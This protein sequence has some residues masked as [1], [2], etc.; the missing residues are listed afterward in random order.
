LRRS[1]VLNFTPK[2][3]ESM[4][5]DVVLLAKKEGLTAHS[6]SVEIRRETAASSQP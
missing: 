5:D 6:L 1:S 4:A 3:L 2:G